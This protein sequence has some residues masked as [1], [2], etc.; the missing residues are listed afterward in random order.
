MNATMWGDVIAAAGF[1][2]TI[3][4]ATWAL[5]SHLTRIDGKLA[6]IGKKLDGE[7]ARLNKEVE[8]IDARTD[9]ASDKMNQ[10]IVAMSGVLPHLAAKRTTGAAQGLDQF[11]KDLLRILLPVVDMERAHANPLTPDELRRLEEYR[12]ALGERL[13][14]PKEAADFQGLVRKM[15]AEHPDNRNLALLVTG[16]ALLVGIVLMLANATDEDDKA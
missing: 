13:L 12:D 1:F 4:G 10:F 5:S 16:A 6:E 3:L 2:T 8:R 9:R 7:I 11:R 15:E 14:T